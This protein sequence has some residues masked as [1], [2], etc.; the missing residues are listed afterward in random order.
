[1]KTDFAG[2]D[3]R[4]VSRMLRPRLDRWLLFIGAVVALTFLG[5]TL[6]EWIKR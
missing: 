1:M 4:S 6:Y 3:R 2:R 5:F